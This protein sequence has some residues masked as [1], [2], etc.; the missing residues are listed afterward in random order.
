MIL[1]FFS[2]KGQFAAIEPDERLRKTAIK[3]VGFDPYTNIVSKSIDSFLKQKH[4]IVDTFILKTDTSLF[5]LRAYHSAFQPFALPTDSLKSIIAE[6]KQV[7]FETKKILDTFWYFQT[8]ASFVAISE[9]EIRKYFKQLHKEIKGAFISHSYVRDR[10]RKEWKG[11]AYS[12]YFKQVGMRSA[13]I[14]WK[15]RNAYLTTLTITFLT[16]LR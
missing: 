8:E 7:N 15:R 1:T 3:F 6:I 14:T 9:G 13:N 4:S 11:E 12:Y 5:Y 10:K 16:K 2:A